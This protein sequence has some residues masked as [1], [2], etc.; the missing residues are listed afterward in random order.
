LEEV[1]ASRMLIHIFLSA[2]CTY[3]LGSLISFLAQNIHIAIKRCAR[4]RDLLT[5]IC[6]GFNLFVEEPSEPTS[7]IVLLE[8]P[9][10]LPVDLAEE[11]TRGAL[12]DRNL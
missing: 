9:G 1:E 3:L 6:F 8:R 12:F 2:S 4:Y 5:I 10:S 7:F 11:D